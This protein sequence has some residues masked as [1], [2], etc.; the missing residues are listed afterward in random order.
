MKSRMK[1]VGMWKARKK[2]PAKCQGWPDLL[3]CPLGEGK[4]DLA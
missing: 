3:L 1:S 4:E 2:P